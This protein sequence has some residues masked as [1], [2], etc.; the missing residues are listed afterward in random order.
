MA[1]AAPD[2]AQ[3]KAEITPVEVEFLTYFIL[4]IPPSD[5]AERLPNV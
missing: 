2:A 4:E 3:P 5:F 1:A